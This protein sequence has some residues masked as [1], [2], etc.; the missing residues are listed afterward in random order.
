MQNSLMS[1]SRFV[2]QRLLLKKTK[3]GRIM[4]V[5]WTPKTRIGIIEPV[6][7][8]GPRLLSVVILYLL[9]CQTVTH[10]NFIRVL[11]LSHTDRG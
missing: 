3:N 9:T 10:A 6:G 2:M 7:E 5:H 11:A 4:T 1:V 8:F